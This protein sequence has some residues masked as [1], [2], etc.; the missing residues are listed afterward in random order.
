M[1]FP[2]VMTY[3]SVQDQEWFQEPEPYTHPLNSAALTFKEREMDA[4]TLYS[5]TSY[6]SVSILGGNSDNSDTEDDGERIGACDSDKVVYADI[7]RD[8]EKERKDDGESVDKEGKHIRS[9]EV[10]IGF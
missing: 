3:V 2:R 4:D 9:S 10:G 7:I 5:D 6:E 8:K 1:Q